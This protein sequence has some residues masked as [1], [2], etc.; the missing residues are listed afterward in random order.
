MSLTMMPSMRDAKFQF[1]LSIV[2]PVYR[3]ED[4]LDALVAAIAEALTPA[5]C[6]YEVVLVNDFSPDNSWAV[7]E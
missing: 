2:V 5:G 4:C 1:D 6:D 3:S 7:I